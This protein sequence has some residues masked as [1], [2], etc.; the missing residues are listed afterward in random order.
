MAARDVG[1][2]GAH[3]PFIHTTKAAF[4]DEVN[5]NILWRGLASLFGRLIDTHLH[6]AGILQ[7][8][9]FDRAALAQAHLEM[10]HRRLKWIQKVDA[11]SPYGMLRAECDE[12]RFALP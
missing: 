4:A 7:S 10:I 3:S 1:A 8:P 6:L 12:R 11:T 5:Q 2:G 9:G